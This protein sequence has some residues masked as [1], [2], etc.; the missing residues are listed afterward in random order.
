V[1]VNIPLRSAVKGAPTGGLTDAERVARK[2][3]E[4]VF[5]VFLRASCAV[6]LPFGPQALER[7]E[8]EEEE[9]A[10]KGEA[11]WGTRREPPR[12]A[13]GHHR[14]ETLH[15]RRKYRLPILYVIVMVSFNGRT[16]FH[17]LEG[18]FQGD[19]LTFEGQNRVPSSII[20]K[21]DLGLL[22]S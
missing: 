13:S 22:P 15:V 7:E 14:E 8:E 4:R 2:Q 1:K 6:T 9:V 10:E 3:R 18:L 12:A 17:F 5:R 19:G 20:M 11:V 21:D 16:F